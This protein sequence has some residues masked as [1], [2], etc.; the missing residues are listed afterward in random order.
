MASPG[1]L[2]WDVTHAQVALWWLT[3]KG[4]SCRWQRSVEPLLEKP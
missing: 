3:P 4:L 1:A 2:P